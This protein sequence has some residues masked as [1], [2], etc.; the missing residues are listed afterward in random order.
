MG[1]EGGVGA[2]RNM[3]GLQGRRGFGVGEGHGA[4]GDQAHGKGDKKCQRIQPTFVFEMAISHGRYCNL[5]CLRRK[6]TL[7]CF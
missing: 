2:L 5:F 1:V 6:I 7:N 4:E 3:Q